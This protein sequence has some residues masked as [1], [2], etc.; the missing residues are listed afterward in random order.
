MAC[1]DF[2]GCGCPT[3]TLMQ[4]GAGRKPGPGPELPEPF[5]GT[6]ALSR[7]RING[8]LKRVI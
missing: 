3:A 2:E 4:Y 6:E 1:E 5:P 8:D 7:E